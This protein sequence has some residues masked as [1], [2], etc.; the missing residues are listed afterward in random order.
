MKF[1]PLLYLLFT[2]S[3]LHAQEPNPWT[4]KNN[5]PG[6]TMDK[7]TS[8]SVGDTG[9]AGL[10]LSLSSYKKDFWQY[11]VQKDEW[12]QLPNF[13]AEARISAV[14]FSIGDKGYIGTGLVGFEGMKQGTNDFWQFDPRTKTWAQKADLP[15]GIR[16]GAVGFSIRDKGYIALGINKNVLYNDLWEYSPATNQ[17]TKKT[18]F[19]VGGR[20][21]A[22]VFVLGGEAYVLLGQRKEMMPSQ[23]D[24]WKYEPKKNEWKQVA[25]F[26]G[27]PRTGA[28]AFAY[29]NKAFV[30][31]GSNGA[32][33]RFED[34]WEYDSFTNQWAH[35]ENVPFGPRAYIFS[36]VVGSNAYIGT[37]HSQKNAS[38]FD[39][40]KYDCGLD[41]K[42]ADKFALGGSFLLGE[43]R[44]PLAAV[45]VRL[46]N[47]KNE[48]V[49]SVSTGLFGSFLLM[50]LLNS[51]EYT[52]VLDVEDP[53]MR[54]QNIY[55]VNREN[56]TVAIFN[57]ENN[58]TF[59]IAKHEKSKLKLIKFENKNIR[60]D[61]RGKLA[62]S[63]ETNSPF[64]NATISLIND[65]EEVVQN[66]STDANGHFSFNYL[67]ADTN[68]Y[69]TIDE[70]ATG[71]LPKGTTILLMDEKENIV[72]KSTADNSSFLLANLPPENNKLATIYMED[73]WLQATLGNFSEALLV[74]ENI[75]F[76]LAKWDLASAAKVVLNKVVI[77]MKN[78]NKISLDIS[79][80]TDSRGEEKA[81]MVLSDKRAQEAKKYIVSQGIDAKRITAKGF[82]E[83]KL[84]NKCANNVECTEE[85]HAMNRRMEFKI[86]RE[87]K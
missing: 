31:C 54:T 66:T 69:L 60:M 22:S 7:A 48:V 21:D 12:D 77:V 20:E 8:F 85:E 17:W 83:T 55:L 33:K 82:G 11:N 5:F 56:E 68:L 52:L 1:L 35:K 51:D 49:K 27:V 45:G 57:L 47:S 29:K 44:I 42:N 36:F 9:Y 46:L 59:H 63:N 50:D 74:V 25:D 38:G 10:G 23:K 4:K 16:Y 87:S 15:A 43:H 58:F 78:N 40:W 81:N 41:K 72:N 14:S 28:L 75:Y 24:C 61:I 64:A 84:L 79:A 34:V 6:G 80:Y 73:P 53:H 86:K 13:P 32:L 39:V 37:G 70:K 3:F 18:D 2:F 62:L 65:Q 71:L 26:P 19:P 67:P 30:L 76:D